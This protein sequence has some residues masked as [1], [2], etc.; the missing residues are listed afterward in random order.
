[1]SRAEFVFMIW[2]W[3][4][5]LLSAGSDVKADSSNRLI[6]PLQGS[7]QK[8]DKPNLEDLDQCPGTIRHYS[9]PPSGYEPASPSQQ[10][11]KG[12]RL[13][14]MLNCE[15][16]HAIDGKGG[17]LGPPLDGIGG[18]RGREWLTARLLDP[19]AQMREFPDVFDGRPNIMPHPSVD[20]KE[21]KR[22]AEYLLTLP[23]PAGGFDLKAHKDV[24]PKIE[25]ADPNFKPRAIDESAKRG[26]KLFIQFYCAACHTIDGGTARFGPDL[27]GI[28]ARRSEAELDRILRGAVDSAAMKAITTQID[29]DELSDLRSFLLTL[30][31]ANRSERAP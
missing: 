6:T 9:F 29:P 26:A 16:C 25:T 14:Q 4:I 27:R 23:E 24:S 10:S 17:E 31:E 11:A 2:L 30:P 28:G 7:V 15:Q 20:K 18:H 21:A 8:I 5:V 22:L 12:K 1:M 3:A 19:E 13:Y